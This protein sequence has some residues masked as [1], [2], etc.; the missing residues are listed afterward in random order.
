MPKTSIIAVDNETVN[1]ASVLE[2]VLTLSQGQKSD[3]QH[4]IFRGGCVV[5]ARTGAKIGSPTATLASI[6][7]AWGDDPSAAVFRKAQDV[8]LDAAMA[9]ADTEY[10]GPEVT[11][12]VLAMEPDFLRFDFGSETLD[13][14]N[15]LEDCYLELMAAVAD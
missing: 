4:A 1:A 13:G 5:R 15:Y 6:S 7:V 12:A 8:A 9:D 11:A 10:V 3:L 2:R 14:S